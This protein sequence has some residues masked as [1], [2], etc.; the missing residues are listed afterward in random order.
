MLALAV[1]PGPTATRRRVRAD[2][3]WQRHRSFALAVSGPLDT[4]WLREAIIRAAPLMPPRS[5]YILRATLDTSIPR[6]KT[7]F[8]TDD[9]LPHLLRLGA[10]VAAS[11]HV[12][13]GATPSLFLSQTR[14]STGAYRSPRTRPTERRHSGA[15]TPS[16]R[17][18]NRCMS[19]S[20][21]RRARSSRAILIVHAPR[22]PRLTRRRAA[23]RAP[24]QVGF[25]T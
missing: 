18:R 6:Q 3:P 7:V 13:A 21:R 11:S 4:A 25:P 8:G 12:A 17:R 5:R 23:A 1:P 19:G 15:R 10:C 16:A 9:D 2:G 20:G 24:R 22:R 14:C